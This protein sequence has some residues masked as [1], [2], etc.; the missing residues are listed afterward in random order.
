MPPSGRAYYD[1]SPE[2]TPELAVFP[3]DIPFSREVNVDFGAG[4]N[5]LASSIHA[6]VHLGA[7]VDAPN[8]YSRSG[9]GIEARG[10]EYY[11][12]DCQVIA[13]SLSRGR[14]IMPADIAHVRGLAPRVLFKTG[15]FPDPN[16]WNGDFNSLSPELIHE[17]SER[18]VILAGIDT[19]SVDPAEDGELRTHQAISERDMA[20]L[21]G[22]V[23]EGVPEGRYTLVALPLR[24]RGADAS[25]VRAILIPEEQGQ[26]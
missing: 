10:L 12:G 14:R 11:F 15:S 9:S 26:L 7:H 25:P 1:I 17:L 5:Y 16:R 18:G 4:A 20:I 24:I 19:P 3:G 6:T 8:H 2:I 21:E 13:V 22:I 23:L